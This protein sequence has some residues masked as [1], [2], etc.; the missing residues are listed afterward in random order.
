MPTSTFFRLP[1]EK[2]TRLLD[3]A[4]DEFVCVPYAEASINRIIRRANIPRGSFYQ[5]FV[6]KRDLFLFLIEQTCDLFFEL[7]RQELKRTRGDIFDTMSGMFDR[8][9]SADGTADPRF[10]RSFTLLKLND[11]VDVHRLFF[12]RAHSEPN[13]RQ[14]LYELIDTSRLK[15][16]GTEYLDCIFTLLGSALGCAVVQTLQSAELLDAE[17]AQL[18]QCIKIIRDGSAVPEGGQNG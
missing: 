7:F 13:S 16:A 14:Q 15:S 6:D 3:A 10:S 2:R 12:E 8:L 4:W 11:S 1:Q 9:F 5:Y 18:H 17:R